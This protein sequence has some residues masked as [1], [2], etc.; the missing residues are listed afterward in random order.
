[1]SRI[2]ANQITNQAAD[3]APTVQHGLIIAG[4]S[5]FTGSVSIGGTLTYE[6]VT[7][8][9]SVG[10]VTA[11]GGIHI[12]D[13]IVHIGDTNTK[14]R[15]PAA[16][17]ITAETGGSERLRIDSDGRLLVG[18]TT[19]NSAYARSIFRGFAGDG[20]TGQGLIHLEVN[21]TTTNCG[22]NEGL[23]GI[24]FASNEGHIGGEIS[25][26]AESAWS[27]SGDLPTYF[28][29]RLCADGSN[30]LTEKLRIASDGT[31]T[32]SGDVSIPE[33]LVHTGDTDTKLRF[34][35][36][37]INFDTTGIERLSVSNGGVVAIGQSSVSNTIPTG[38]LDIQGNGTNCVLEM[39]NPFPG[40]NS[41]MTPELR[42]TTVDASHTVEFRTVW[43]G[44]NGLYKHLSFSGGNTSI[45][46][47]IN[48]EALVANFNGTGTTI[49]KTSLSINDAGVLLYTS[50]TG[51]FSRASDNPLGVN[52]LTNT[53][54]LIE[55]RY[56]GVNRGTISTN[57]TN[58]AYNTSA[59][60][61]T[62]KKNFEDWTE[63]VLPY[64][65]SLNPQKFNFIDQI[66]ETDKVKGYIAQD[67]V[68]KFPE[69][70]PKDEKTD[71]YWFN[72]PGMVSYLMKA[73]QEEIVKRETLEARVA[74]LE[75]S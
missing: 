44:T 59:S 16:D 73:L 14:I 34:G 54:A 62:L 12:D 26:S 1:M 2:R 48:T 8:I 36:N 69:A 24:R 21:R 32:F 67:L 3:G 5:T 70:Y 68:D 28:R 60:D 9:D 63:E 22:A 49:G 19:N 20:G 38:G 47:G 7:N 64:F 13:S 50:G 4:V 35:T 25:A 52:R 11:R 66:D 61:R 29:F 74:A 18:A 41:G 30:S 45:Y 23:G 6:D 39:G 42:I 17:T 56:A 40:F 43:G 33:N 57:G 10:I 27:G 37:T 31:S 58:V 51:W 71:K 55:L 46:D 72:P 53:G 15:F 75:G 65:K